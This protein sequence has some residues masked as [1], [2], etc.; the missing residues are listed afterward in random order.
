M[1]PKYQLI[2]TH[3]YLLQYATEHKTEKKITT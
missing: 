2:T 3:E 1:H